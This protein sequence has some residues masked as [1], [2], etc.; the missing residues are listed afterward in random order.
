MK[1]CWDSNPSKRP[2]LETLLRNKKNLKKK[3]NYQQHQMKVIL[4]VVLKNMNYMILKYQSWNKLFQLP[5]NQ[6]VL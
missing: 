3:L 5:L 6:N 2:R 1:Q 4:K